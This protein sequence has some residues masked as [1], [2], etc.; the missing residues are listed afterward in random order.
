MDAIR[1][2]RE[3]ERLDGLFIHDREEDAL[4]TINSNNK[5]TTSS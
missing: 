5:I 3:V 2:L 1:L 4:Q